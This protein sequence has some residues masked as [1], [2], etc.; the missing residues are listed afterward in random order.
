MLQVRTFG[1]AEGGIFPMPDLREGET[2]VLTG[3]LDPGTYVMFCSLP[4]HESLGTKG[5]LIVS[6]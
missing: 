3:T 4:G 6:A 5:T 1:K 2:A